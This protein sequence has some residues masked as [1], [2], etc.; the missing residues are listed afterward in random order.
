MMFSEAIG[1]FV[2]SRE[3]EDFAVS[4]VRLDRRKLQ[5]IMDL[6]GDMPVHEL[7]RTH[8]DRVSR[9]EIARGIS[10]GTVNTYQSSFASFCKW[11]VYSGY[12][13]KNPVEGRRYRKHVP[14]KKDY[15]PIHQFPAL[16]DAAE[17]CS[18]SGTRDRAFIAAG[19][20]LMMRQS[21]LTDLRIKDL[22]LASGTI[23]ARIF[24]T[25]EADVMPVSKEFDREMRKYLVYYEEDAGPLQPDWYLFPATRRFRHDYWG[26][27]PKARISKPEQIVHRTIKE[28]GFE[29]EGP[30]GV[31][32][33]RRSAARAAL[34]ELIAQGYDGA[35]RRVQAWLH[36]KNSWTT[37]VYLGLTQDREIRNRE[38]IGQPLF[39]SLDSDNVVP[40]TDRR[41][42][43]SRDE[44]AV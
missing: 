40:L 20:Y 2:Q 7:K 8:F 31:H 41:A 24:K 15:I 21:E 13:D 6:T 12:M 1:L 16:L 33:L 22:D 4:T 43:E 42:R 23:D 3:D 32:I 38:T 9:I 10:D 27:L 5:R 14:A 11:C 34:D 37:E 26:M 25:R 18:M 29:A 36:H 35:L 30:V 44:T 17:R 28:L 19:L 39:P